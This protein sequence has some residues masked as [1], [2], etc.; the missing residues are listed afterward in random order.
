VGGLAVGIPGEVHGFATAH[1]KSG[2][3]PWQ[4]IWQPSIDLARKG[5][6]IPPVLARITTREAQFFREHREDWEFLFNQDSGELLRVGE[7][8]KRE[9]YAQTLE[10]IAGRGEHGHDGEYSGV[11][12]FYNGSIAQKLVEVANMHGGILTTDDFSRYHTVVKETIKTRFHGREIITCPPPCSGAVLI[13][14]LN[15]AEGLSMND[16]SD[17]LSYHYLIEYVSVPPRFCI[18]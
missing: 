15:I 18:T 5:F 17:P 7:L 6:Q 13:E 2:K 1:A 10:V 16:S 3:L 14:G 11:S 8:M 9:A 12:Q 4:E